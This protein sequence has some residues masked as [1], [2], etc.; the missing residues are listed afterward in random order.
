MSSNNIIAAALASSGV[1]FHKWEQIGDA[2]TGE[3]IAVEPEQERV[4]RSTDLAYWPDGKPRMRAVVTLQ[5]TLATDENDDGQRLVPIPLYGKHRERLAA[6]VK[7]AGLTDLEPGMSFGA[8]WKSGAGGSQDPR[9]IE[10][11]VDPA[12]SHIAEAIEQEPALSPEQSE[13]AAE[14]LKAG[15]ARDLVANTLGVPES[16]LADVPGF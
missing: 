5:T 11:A 9:V 1:R 3:I 12:P 4:Y 6:A 14:L 15:V 10:Y 7:E 13:K 2:I 8:T 16:A